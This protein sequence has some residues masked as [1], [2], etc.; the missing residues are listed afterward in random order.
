MK[1]MTAKQKPAKGKPREWV[2]WCR[3]NTVGRGIHIH[4]T[5]IEAEYAAEFY[6]QLAPFRVRITEIVK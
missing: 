1:K 4:G 5:K 6:G 2:R 3:A